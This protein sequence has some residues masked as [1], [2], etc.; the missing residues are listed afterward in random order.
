MR[1]YESEGFTMPCLGF[2]HAASCWGLN[3]FVMSHVTGVVQSII[4]T[5]QGEKDRSFSGGCRR[6]FKTLFKTLLIIRSLLKT[7]S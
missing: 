6:V 3:T 4:A 2:R 5:N 1:E 7:L